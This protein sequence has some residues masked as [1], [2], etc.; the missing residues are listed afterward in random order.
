MRMKREGIE[1]TIQCEGD[2][3]IRHYIIGE[4]IETD[5]V[6]LNIP[7]EAG[8]IPGFVLDP[9]AK[10]I[11]HRMDSEDVIYGLGE[12]VRGM[13]KRN[14][15]YISNNTDDYMHTEGKHSLYASQNFILVFSPR[16]SFGLYVDTPGRVTFDLGYTDP[17]VLEIRLDDFDANL[18]LVQDLTLPGIA[19][20]FRQLVGR[21]Y[22]PPKWAFGFG[23]SRWSYRTEKE[24]EEVADRY[25]KE[26]IPLDSIYLDIDYM[27]HYKDFTVDEQAFPDF[28]DFCAKMK[29]RGI[30]LVPIIDAGVKMEDGYDICEEGRKSDYFVKDEDGNDLVAAVWPGKA[31]FPDFMKPE[32]RKWF[33]EHYRFLLD[34]GVDGF[35]N[36]M[37]E[38]AIFYTEKHLNEVFRRIDELKGENLDIDSFSELTSL[39]GGLSNNPEDYRSFYHRYKGKSYRHDKLHNLYGYLM[40]RAAGEAFRTLC[41]DRRILLFSRSSYIGMHRYGG[42][43]TG[44]NRSWWEHLLLS[45]QQMAGL[46]LCGFLY[47][48]SDMGGFGDDTTEDLMMRWL[49]M[50]LFTPLY[51]NHNAKGNRFQELSAFAHPERFRPI[52]E[53]RYAL[54][55]YI[56]SE[57][58]KAALRDG[59]YMMPLAFQWP[60]DRRAVETEDQ[61][62]VGE[63]VM[64]AP[65]YRQNASGRYVYLP[66]DMMLLRM[67]SWND[68]DEIQ[69]SEG[70][71]YVKAELGEVLIFIRKGHVLPLCHPA[72]NTA[73]LDYSTIRYICNGGC[74]EDYELYNDDG[75]TL[76]KDPLRA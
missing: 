36:D 63:S 17:D 64:I 29:K 44:D 30:H 37:N 14:W 54:L 15:L 73:A 53:L 2:T 24:V 16:A 67:R 9:G 34:Q 35:W 38:P 58:M 48:G 52:I 46:N 6:V 10:T 66:E 31:H 72:A 21:S 59:M 50:A 27:D 1:K 71:H 3:M 33:G 18:Y 41:P 57:F 76:V 61:L 68:Y 49:E 55:P 56:Y 11:R 62:L 40:T 4:P 12:T 51:R 43:W 25:Q 22:I 47:S 8:E 26:G 74:P 65:V 75:I 20:E 45:M 28:A 19:H 42:V 5:S 7:V 32:T 13:N 69:L 39:V 60:D 23:Q 70:D